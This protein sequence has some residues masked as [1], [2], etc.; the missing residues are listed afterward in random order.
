MSDLVE[1][2]R[3]DPAWDQFR[4]SMLM[5]QAADRIEQL[6]RVLAQVREALCSVDGVGGVIRW[7]GQW[8]KCQN[9]I[10]AI[11]EALNTEAQRAAVGGPTGA[12]S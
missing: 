7:N 9:A 2:L 1:R 3:N 6:E 11:D 4:A 8:E 5:S 10:A 12:Q